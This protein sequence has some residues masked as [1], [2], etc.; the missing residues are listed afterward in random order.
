M[1]LTSSFAG[2]QPIA[3]WVTPVGDVGGVARHVLDVARAGIPGW[4]L[5]VLCPEGPIVQEL[6]QVGVAVL[7]AKIGP[8]HGIRT[9]L[10]EVHHA[11]SRLRPAVVHS[12]LAYA[13]LLVALGAR[14]AVRVSTEHGIAD[15]DLV[16]HGSQARAALRARAHQLRVRRF[17]AL[18]A[19]S[20]A[21]A[22]VMRR[23]WHVNAPI[24]VIPNGIDRTATAAAAARQPGRRY[25][26]L[27]R[28][29]PEKRLTDLVAAFAEVVAEQSDA[30]LTIAGE[31][32]ERARVEAAVASHGLDDQVT[33]PGFLD[34]D[35]AMATHDVVAQLSAFENCS[36]TLLD[37]VVNG[38]GVVASPVGGNPEILPHRCLADPDATMDVAAALARQADTIAERPVL[39]ADWPTV[40][41]MNQRIADTYAEV[42]S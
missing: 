12:H 2:S 34:A 5:V 29:S 40:A 16:Y 24:T 18:I 9:G 15:D 33:L 11:V 14:D 22:A 23:K 32:C 42:A 7:P 10:S 8:E 39:P 25:L 28:L 38:L 27:S 21:T 41:D 19:V 35:Q 13:D 26:S 4:R 20:R 36:Y 6:R 17:H 30:T 3:L 31:G 1:V 37:A